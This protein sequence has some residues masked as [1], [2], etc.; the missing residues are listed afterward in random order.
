MICSYVSSIVADAVA[1]ED[2]NVI[3]LGLGKPRDHRLAG[4]IPSGGLYLLVVVG[5]GI[6]TKIAKILLDIR[7]S[8][9][10]LNN[11]AAILQEPTRVVVPVIA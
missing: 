1:C 8:S 5:S 4:S 9:A 2:T 6:D 3:Y 7:E 11:N 10:R